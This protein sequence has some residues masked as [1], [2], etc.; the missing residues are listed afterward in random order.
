MNDVIRRKQLKRRKRFIGISVIVG[1]QLLDANPAISRCAWKGARVH[2]GSGY[3]V[4]VNAV[5]ILEGYG[6]SRRAV[7]T[8][9]ER[10]AYL[11]SGND[12]VSL[13]P[14]RVYHGQK[15]V[16]LVVLQPERPLKAGE[17]YKMY[18][19]SIAPGALDY[20][21][22][23]E[24]REYEWNAQQVVDKTAPALLSQ[25]SVGRSRYIEYGCGPAVNVDIHMETSQEYILFA[26]VELRRVDKPEKKPATYLLPVERG[27]LTIGHGMCSGAF[28]LSRDVEY[29][30]RI[31]LVDAAGNRSPDG[32]GR[33]TF[34]GPSPSR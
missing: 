18:A 6:E 15:G 13:S 10:S 34:F 20:Y 19:P 29:E 1:F 8:M 21:M 7:E 24:R 9:E 11:Q 17:I 32:V 31:T 27:V 4:P 5:F 28:K 26:E 22:T 30:A 14:R 33:C 3:P 2:P 16:S 25:P 12:R 23:G